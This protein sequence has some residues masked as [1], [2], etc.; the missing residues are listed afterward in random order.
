MYNSS[1][2]FILE[3]PDMDE[4]HRYLYELFDMLGTSET[5]LNINATRILLAEIERF[6]MF[7][8]FCE[9]KLM[10]IYNVSSFAVHQS[11]H[12]KIAN[13]II[14]FQDEFDAGKLNPYRMHI[15]LG[16]WLMEHS[17]LVDSEYVPVI[18][19]QREIVKKGTSSIL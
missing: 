16:S 5:V 9:E 13:K 1:E 6:I 11:D 17:R 12:E 2:R 15:I 7:H 18:K 4:Q 3:L 8:F 10:R 19:Q 14:E